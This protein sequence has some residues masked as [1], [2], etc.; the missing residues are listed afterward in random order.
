MIEL[1][2]HLRCQWVWILFDHRNV[3][4]AL[5]FQLL[6]HFECRQ[7]LVVVNAELLQTGFQSAAA[8]RVHD[9]RKL[10]R[11]CLPVRRPLFK[12]CIS[13]ALE[14]EVLGVVAEACPEVEARRAVDAAEA[15]HNSLCVVRSPDDGLQIFRA[16]VD[17]VEENFFCGPRSCL[18]E[19]VDVEL[20]IYSGVAAYRIIDYEQFEL[21]GSAV[22]EEAGEVCVC[23]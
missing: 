3:R 20:R 5:R 18:R 10:R 17:T 15:E 22:A 14:T 4:H 1:I 23:V 19:R 9:Q 8:D 6:L 7:S 12:I 13:S 2:L 21:C 11:V 16:E